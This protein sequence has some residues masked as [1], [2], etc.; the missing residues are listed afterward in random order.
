MRHVLLPDGSATVCGI[1]A[2]ALGQG[3]R[4]THEA[5][6][7]LAPPFCHRCRVRLLSRPQLLALVVEG[8]RRDGL[9]LPEL[10]ALELPS[11]ALSP[12][13][14]HALEQRRL[15][16]RLERGDYDHRDRALRLAVIA[17]ASRGS[18]RLPF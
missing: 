1:D 10:A 11:R 9:A 13:Q 16:C 8:L 15:A 3:R 7:E 5:Q 14:R 6:R 12:R 17:A 4:R 2:G 18:E